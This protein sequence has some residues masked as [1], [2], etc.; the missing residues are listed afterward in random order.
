MMLAL[1]V[2]PIV[3]IYHIGGVDEGL[4]LIESVDPSKLDMFSGSSLIGIISLMAW[5]LGYFGQPHILVRFMS[6]RHEDELHRAKAIGMS[7]MILSI[8]G[9]LA[10]GFFGF[11]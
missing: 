8:I 7:W 2:T 6:I 4:R 3:V 5:G 10:V 9:S 11:A 1:V